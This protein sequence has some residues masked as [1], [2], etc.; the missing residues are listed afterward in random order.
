M[1]QSPTFVKS[2]PTNTKHIKSIENSSGIHKARGGICFDLDINQFTQHDTKPAVQ[3]K[4]NAYASRKPKKANTKEEILKR[5]Q[6]AK[7]YDKEARAR[8]FAGY[9]YLEYFLFS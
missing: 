5:R 8:V 4:L 1:N 2:N 6:M 7:N 3:P 9:W